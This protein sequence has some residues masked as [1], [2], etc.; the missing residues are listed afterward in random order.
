MHPLPLL[1]F[2]C[3]FHA[4]HVVLCA[5]AALVSEAMTGSTQVTPSIAQ[6]IYQMG[7]KA[8]NFLHALKG[9]Q[10]K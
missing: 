2:S 4:P 7:P 8:K 1:F 9:Q 10:D 6:G 5:V 3:P